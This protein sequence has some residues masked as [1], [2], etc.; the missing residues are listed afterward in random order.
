MKKKRRKPIKRLNHAMKVR[1]VAVSAFIA[2]LFIGLV[3]RLVYFSVFKNGIYKRQVLSQQNY[4]SETLPYKRGDILDRNGN[5]L[6]TSQKMYQLVL[7][8]K[9]IL[10]S[11]TIKEATLDALTKYMGLDVNDLTKF[12]ERHKNSYY[13]LYREELSYSQISDLKDFLAGDQAE[14]VSGIVFSEKYKRRYP[15]KSLASQVLGFVSDGTIGTGGIEQYYNSTLSG[16]D[17]RKYKYLNEELEQDSSIVEPEN[18]K[19][20]V[21][22]ID[23]NIQK[24]AEKE[25]ETFE[26]KYGSKGS[27]ILVMNP[28]NGEVYAMANS[29]SYNLENPRDEK[30]LLKKYSQS[31]IQKMT[32]KERAEAFN[33]IWKNPIVSD[34][35]EPGS[36]YKPFTVAAGLEEG[37]LK[38]NET[39]DCDGFQIVGPHK[40]HCSHRE[41]HGHITLSQSISLSCNDALMQI[42]AKE[43]NTVFAKY[44][45]IFNFGNFTGIDLPGEAQTASLL[46]DAKDMKPADLATSSF[47]QSFNCSMIQ[48]GS[49]FCSLINGGNYYK[50]H[51]V[52]QMRSDEGNVTANVEPTLVKQTVS[53]ETSDKL[54]AYMK[55]TVD[56]GTGI[57]AQLKNYTAGGK[58]GTAQKIPRSAGTYIVSFCG[59]AP[60]ENPQ[61]VVYVV[62]DEIQ[63]SSQTNTGLAV[64]IAK[65][66]LEGSLKELNVPKSSKK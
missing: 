13:A 33:E 32:K 55:E 62:I 10:R 16:V 39:Y 1:A 51:I 25:L 65:N 4:T 63:K 7:E 53:K 14:N 11:K 34:A 40:I 20:I 47:G 17:G 22:T 19:T 58:T 18:G 3:G 37:I 52:K 12:I 56:S 60:V 64:E 36:T 66:V 23:S 15:N 46:H 6:A 45:K 61:V 29:T 41:G 48:L 21:T 59:F 54:K 57:K 27:S 2:L 50:P 5:T 31:E 38:G 30:I 44:Q 43:G 24:L 42:A 28:N 8:P 9:N 35:F 49:A 26:K